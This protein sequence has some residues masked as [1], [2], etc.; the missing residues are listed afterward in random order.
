MHTQKLTHIIVGPGPDD[1]VPIASHNIDVA[2]FAREEAL[3]QESVLNLC[4]ANLWHNGSYASGCPR[5]VL[6]GE[7]HQQQ[8]KDLH[9]ALT[10]AIADIVQRW[11]SD[12]DARFP[13]RMPLEPR[14]EE[15]LK[16]SLL[17]C[18]QFREKTF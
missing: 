8:M 17:S 11:W 18:R 7:H 10:A 12:T 13:E 4:P 9:K 6:V 5:P 1:V 16:V 14:E 2:S 15:L 3:L